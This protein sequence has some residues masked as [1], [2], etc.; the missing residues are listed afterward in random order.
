M[1]F[2]KKVIFFFYR[3]IVLH[4]DFKMWEKQFKFL[5][6]KKI[7]CNMSFLI[8]SIFTMPATLKFEIILSTLL[9]KK[10]ILVIFLSEKEINIT[11]N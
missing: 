3:K 8:C 4:T 9:Y 11:K 7:N 6:V 10:I 2:F 1:E 5:C